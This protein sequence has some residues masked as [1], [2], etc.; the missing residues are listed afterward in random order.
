MLP[1]APVTSTRR[2]TR[3]WEISSRSIFTRRLPSRSS[4]VKSRISAAST[5][6]SSRLCTTGRILTFSFE[7]RAISTISLTTVE[8]ADGIAIN[9]ADAP[10]R[11][12]TFAISFRP[13]STG[14]P[15]MR[16]RW[17]LGLSSR[18]ATGKYCELG[19]R[20]IVLT[21]WIPPSPAP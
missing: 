4:S 15:E 6:R 19:L 2:F 16:K 5:C 11:W 9:S 21:I 7:L 3:Y 20:S 18:N 1:P 14:T 10:V 8:S 12:A 17:V 13:P